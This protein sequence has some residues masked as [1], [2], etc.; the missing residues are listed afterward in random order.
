MVVFRNW[1]ISRAKLAKMRDRALDPETDRYAN[2][3]APGY[4][5]YYVERRLAKLVRGKRNAQNWG[6]H[7]AFIG[8]S[9]GKPT[10]FESLITFIRSAE[11]FHNKYTIPTTQ[12]VFA[13][14]FCKERSGI[15]VSTEEKSPAEES[16]LRRRQEDRQRDSEVALRMLL[17]H[18]K[19]E[20]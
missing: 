6:S 7:K 14:A 2:Q 1:M 11:A 4:D 20:E 18:V 12:N 3:L 10:E 17:Q 9:K 5:A 15:V 8:L 19:T 13:P 16:G